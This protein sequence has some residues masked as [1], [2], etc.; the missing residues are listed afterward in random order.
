ME[1]IFDRGEQFVKHDKNAKTSFFSESFCGLY[2]NVSSLLDR[3]DR[4]STRLFGHNPEIHALPPS[5]SWFLPRLF[6]S[7]CH[8]DSVGYSST[9]VTES[10]FYDV[11][12]FSRSIRPLN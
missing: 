10:G 2:K 7:S 1:K 4:L 9:Y 6:Y 5:L 3:I 12:S 11:I 8:F